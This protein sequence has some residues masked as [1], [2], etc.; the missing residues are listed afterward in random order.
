MQL[1]QPYP[2]QVHF[3]LLTFARFVTEEQR[4][5]IVRNAAQLLEMHHRLLAKLQRVE[6]DLGWIRESEDDQETS[7]GSS[8]TRLKSS[9]A[10]VT[11]AARRIC[12]IFLNESP[13]I[14]AAYKPF[15][16]G[17]IET[18]EVTKALALQKS[19][20]D[21]FET[22]CTG[23]LATRKSAST[24]LHFADF[25]IKPVQRV[26]RYPL[27]FANLV[28]AAQKQELEMPMGR[29]N[30]TAAAFKDV[31]AEVDDA[32]RV[33]NREI[34]TVKLALRLDVQNVRSLSELWLSATD[35]IF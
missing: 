31:A 4:T 24:R 19:D 14:A 32:Q 13:N 3:N 15:C 21:A 17:H 1:T 30:A 11:D 35:I 26:C 6:E 5:I 20:W 33:R 22:S 9:D 2:R 12:S 25:L 18:M 28:K 34:V 10:T 16:S 7:S 8:S 23:V 29:L 27:L